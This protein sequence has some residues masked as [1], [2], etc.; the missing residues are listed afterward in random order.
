MNNTR[1]T[2][3]ISRITLMGIA[4]ISFALIEIVSN[5]FVKIG[6]GIMAVLCYVNVFASYFPFEQ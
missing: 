4:L 1:K 5:P 3:I 2:L 6:L